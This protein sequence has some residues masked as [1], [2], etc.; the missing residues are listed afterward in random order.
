MYNA[1]LFTSKFPIKKLMRVI[2][3]YEAILVEKMWKSH[4]LN[5]NERKAAILL[6]QKTTEN[7]TL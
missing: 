4:F 7:Y 2:H 3:W 6:F 5:E 1:Q